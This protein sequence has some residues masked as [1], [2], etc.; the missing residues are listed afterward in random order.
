MKKIIP[1]HSEPLN[2]WKPIPG[3]PDYEASI[4]GLIRRR[5]K[6]GYTVQ[7]PYRKRN[8][9]YKTIYFFKIHGKEYSYH[10]KVYEAFYGA[11]PEGKIVI[12]KDGIASNNAPHNLAVSEW[13]LLGKRYGGKSTSKSVLQYDPETMEIT[14]VYRSAREASR[15]NFFS[16]QTITSRCNG[17][18]KYASSLDGKEYCWEDDEASYKMMCERIRKGKRSREE[19]KTRGRHKKK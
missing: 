6:N 17:D 15:Q 13:K 12:H 9:F 11:V 14:A 5:F 4:E 10:R 16:H 2:F 19:K 7:K 3:H 18:V 8:Q 1:Y